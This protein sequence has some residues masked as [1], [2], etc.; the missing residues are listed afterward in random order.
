MNTPIGFLL[1]L[2]EVIPNNTKIPVVEEIDEPNTLFDELSHC[3]CHFYL[4]P[5]QACSVILI[6]NG[7]E[8]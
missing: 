5:L 6:A 1:C 8:Q 7:M 4:D 2:H 3:V